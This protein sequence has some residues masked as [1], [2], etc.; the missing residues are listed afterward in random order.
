MDYFWLTTLDW[1]TRHTIFFV[2]QTFNVGIYP[3]CLLFFSSLYILP[4]PHQLVF[5]SLGSL[6]FFHLWNIKPTWP[7]PCIS[8]AILLPIVPPSSFV[9]CIQARLPE[10]QA[11]LLHLPAYSTIGTISTSFSFP[12]TPC[13][14]SIDLFSLISLD[15]L[16]SFPVFWKRLKMKNRNNFMKRVSLMLIIVGK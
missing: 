6:L 2:H 1:V 5:S 11:S 13:Y 10:V 4:H 15:C 9:P 8:V 12:Q 14:L 16:Q 3:S 7:T